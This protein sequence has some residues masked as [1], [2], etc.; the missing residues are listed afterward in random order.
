MRSFFTRKRVIA[1]SVVAV[2]AVSAAAFAYWTTSG[3]GTGSASTGTSSAVTVTQVGSISNL[4]PGSS[5]QAVDFK[6]N[7]GSSEN[8][9]ISAVAVSISSVT[10]P[11]ADAGHPCTASD[12][13]L[14]QPNAINADLTSGDHTYSP[15]GATLALKN[16]AS[17]QD[18]C[19]GATVNLAFNA[20]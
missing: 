14:V 18:G 15:S 4:K 2:L 1:M 3:T 12:F 13:D 5:A 10:A 11:N 17:N 20:S 19:K 16:T 9:Y 8:Q 6:I 7:N